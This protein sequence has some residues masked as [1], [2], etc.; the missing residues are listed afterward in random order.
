M[1]TDNITKHNSSITNS[2]QN[3]FSDREASIY[4]IMEY[5]IGLRDELGESTPDIPLSLIHI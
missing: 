4:R 1:I 2:L 5:Q 3:I